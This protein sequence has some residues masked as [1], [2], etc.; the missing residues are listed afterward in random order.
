MPTVRR[1]TILALCGALFACLAASARAAVP[2]GFVGTESEELLDSSAAHRHSAP[3][4]PTPAP[5][6]DT[7][8][9]A[10]FHPPPTTRHSAPHKQ[11]AAGVTTLRQTFDWARIE[12]RRGRFD[13][14]VYDRLALDAAHEG[15]T[16]MPLL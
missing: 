1:L 5:C 7:K 11:P 3:R 8:T 14:G 2:D 16:L 9:K 15:I 6:G 12:P 10:P 13:F 4:P